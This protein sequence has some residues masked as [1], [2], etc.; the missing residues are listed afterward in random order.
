[1][2]RIVGVFRILGS[3]KRASLLA[4]CV[5]AAIAQQPAKVDSCGFK[6]N[7]HDCHC[8]QR[9]DNI[10]QA[11]QD[12]CKTSTHSDKERNECLK[13]E[14]RDHCS[15]AER[16]TRWDV[17]SS[18]EPVYEGDNVKSSMGEFCKRAC[19]PHH[20]ACTEESCDFK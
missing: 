19:K 15:M 5:V 7:I 10:R 16:R 20:C 2:Q 11:V 8:S 17:D 6:G 18:S 13:V 4:L 9:T 3:G 1:M 12:Y 14:N